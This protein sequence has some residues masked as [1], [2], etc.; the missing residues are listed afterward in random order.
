[1]L[2]GAA[3]QGK[4]GADKPQVEGSTKETVQL[5]EKVARFGFVHPNGSRCAARSEFGFSY[6]LVEYATQPKCYAL[7]EA[8]PLVANFQHP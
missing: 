5:R 2:V 6:V 1:M 3:G 4:E 8:H 7:P